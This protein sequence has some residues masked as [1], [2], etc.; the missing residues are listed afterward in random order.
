MNKTKILP[1]QTSGI[2]PKID[3]QNGPDFKL[4]DRYVMPELSDKEIEIEMK[5]KPNGKY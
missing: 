2:N 3:I 5:K 4:K 1:S